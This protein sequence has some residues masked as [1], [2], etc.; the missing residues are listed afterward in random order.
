MAP[1]EKTSSPMTYPNPPVDSWGP[2]KF[3]VRTV[4]SEV[5]RA[6]LK[7]IIKESIRELYYDEYLE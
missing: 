2:P 7:E 6:E 4:F 5:E 3:P 1:K